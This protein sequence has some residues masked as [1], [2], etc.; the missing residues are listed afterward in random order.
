MAARHDAA[1]LPLHGSLDADAQDAALSP[2]SQRRIIVAT[3]IAETSLTVPGVAIVIDSGLHK[4]ARYNSERGVD[5]LTLERITTDSADQRA[6]RAARLGPG[7]ARRLWDERDRLRPHREPE[8]HRIDLAGPVLS[9]MAWG[10]DPN[11]FEWFERPLDDRIRAALAL[12]ERLG[13]ARDGQIT[14][15]GAACS[16]CRCTRDLHGSCSTAVDRSK[17]RRRAPGY[18]NH[19]GSSA[20]ARRLTCDLLPIIDAWRRM[21]APLN[22]WPRAFN[23][24]PAACSVAN[25]APTST[26]RCCGAHYWRAIRTASRSGVAATGSRCR[27][28]TAP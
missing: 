1:V 6:G 24:P 25:N 17:R 28:G 7:V 4:V 13:A 20:A 22:G 19:R 8:I 10:G 21:P 23:A 3:N 2:G 27:A 12:L 14:P 16:D 5:S 15:W 9:I 26:R 18:R 11:T